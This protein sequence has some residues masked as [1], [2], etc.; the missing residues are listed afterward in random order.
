VLLEFD[1][2]DEVEPAREALLAAEL[3]G[4]AEIVPAARTVLVAFE[5]GR[6]DPAAASRAVEG[7]G[8]RPAER[9]GTE[10]VLGV[11]YD[12]PDLALVAE[13]AGRTV[14]E[15]TALHC[16]REYRVAFCG[17]APGFGYLTGL[18][19]ALHQPRLVD[20]RTRVERGSV[21]IAGEFSAVYPQ[22]SPGG[23]RL[24]GHTDA[25]LFDPAAE[26][27]AV[28]AP[29]DTVSFRRLP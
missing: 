22:A 27:P 23:W 10:H 13:T 14:E 26:Q 2:L 5:P 8:G 17:F 16:G 19:E 12:G 11:H 28:L 20:P 25:V 18:P 7:A 3:A 4:V 1:A 29:G 15:V 6:A 9:V 21:G 24:I